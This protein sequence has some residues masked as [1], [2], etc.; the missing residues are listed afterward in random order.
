[1]RECVRERE[2]RSVCVS[3]HVSEAGRCDAQLNI[4]LCV[5]V[6]VSVSACLCV[7]VFV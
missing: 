3:E 6:C 1:M 7:C 5:C 4:R 2:C